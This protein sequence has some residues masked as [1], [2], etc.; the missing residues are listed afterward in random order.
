[1]VEKIKFAL[2]T[3]SGRGFRA[4]ALEHP[5]SAEARTLV[6][7]HS[8]VRKV[9]AAHFGENRSVAFLVG[10]ALPGEAKRK[11][12]ATTA[13]VPATRREAL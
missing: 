10:I 5:L 12:S 3:R 7:L 4:R 2:G 9:V 1:M 8:A 13:T 11:G 6:E